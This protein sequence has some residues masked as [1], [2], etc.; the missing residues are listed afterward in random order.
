MNIINRLFGKREVSIPPI[1]VGSEDLLVEKVSEY[2]KSLLPNQKMELRLSSL[3]N[4]HLVTNLFFTSKD[5]EAQTEEK[6]N[7]VNVSIVVDNPSDKKIETS[8]SKTLYNV[9]SC[10]FKKENGSNW[11]TFSKS[12]DVKENIENWSDQKRNLNLEENKT[13]CFW[14]IA[15]QVSPE[16]PFG[17]FL[18]STSE[19]LRALVSSKLEEMYP[20]QGYS[21][22]DSGLSNQGFFS[23]FWASFLEPFSALLSSLLSQAN[24]SSVT[25]S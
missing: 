1:K 25:E 15:E 16:F 19:K 5:V 21:T 2:V 13:T 14:E 7:N 6:K 3:Q 20:T 10:L 17:V 4:P 12:T 8:P 22:V 9:Q 24:R 11:S 18:K 23:F